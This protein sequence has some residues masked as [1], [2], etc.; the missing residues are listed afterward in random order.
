MYK[1][2]INNC[3]GGFSVSNEALELLI[4]MGVEVKGKYLDWSFP[5]HDK[6]LVE[7]VEMLGEKANGF[8][9][10]LKICQVDAQGYKINAF[11]GLESVE[12]L[13]DD[14]VVF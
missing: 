1:V 11:D 7:V 3:F 10:K 2:V 9:A 4:A 5:R 6:R 13:G 8:G 12:W 14:W